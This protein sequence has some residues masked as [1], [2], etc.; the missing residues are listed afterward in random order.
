MLRL[1][2]PLRGYPKGYTCGGGQHR[3][4]ILRRSL[5]GGNAEVH[6]KLNDP[7]LI[8]YLCGNHNIS[9]WPD[10]PLA[11]AYLLIRNNRM[12]KGRTKE[13][14]DALLWKNDYEDMTWKGL[15]DVTGVEEFRR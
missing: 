5:G 15:T 13:V 9:R 12:T 2:C 14:V 8:T 4:H 7:S 10:E 1:I 11:R 6:K 3:H